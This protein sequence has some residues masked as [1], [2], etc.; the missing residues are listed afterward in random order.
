M[1]NLN[2]HEYDDSNKDLFAFDNESDYDEE[3][4]EAKSNQSKQ[5]A[6]KQYEA[7]KKIESL[8][9]KRRLDCELD[10]YNN[11]DLDD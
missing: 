11:F 4:Q 6:K 8:L 2:Q 10:D 1:A 5:N 3:E 9:E 7:R